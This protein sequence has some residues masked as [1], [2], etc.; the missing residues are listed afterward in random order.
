MSRSLLLAPAA[1]LLVGT[2]SGC[3]GGA[4]EAS[5]VERTAEEQFSQQFPVESVDC[6][7]DLPAEVGETTVCTLVSEGR[8][9]EMTA[10]VTEVDDD[11]ASFDLEL[12]AE[13]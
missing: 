6:P 2:L 4:V 11:D 7:E 12:T 9:F 1:L 8:S 10:T 13:N 5:E 3:G